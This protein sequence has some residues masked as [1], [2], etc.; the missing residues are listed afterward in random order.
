ML[1]VFCRPPN[2]FFFFLYSVTQF[3]SSPRLLFLAF[4]H[5]RRPCL[6]TSYWHDAG[7]LWWIRAPSVTQWLCPQLNTQGGAEGCSQWAV[8]FSW[9]APSALS[10]LPFY[11]VMLHLNLPFF[12]RVCLPVLV[13]LM[14]LMTGRLPCCLFTSLAQLCAQSYLYSLS[15][16]L[17]WIDVPDGI[18]PVSR[19]HQ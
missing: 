19:F 1:F 15:F 13:L 5:W 10:H 12:M 16:P 11:P 6:P 9:R 3:D 4:I 8:P 2:L 17:L 18:L 14:H 7:W